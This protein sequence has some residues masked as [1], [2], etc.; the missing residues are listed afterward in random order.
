MTNDNQLGGVDGGE[1]TPSLFVPKTHHLRHRSST[2]K[3]PNYL[4]TETYSSEDNEKELA[5][6]LKRIKDYEQLVIDCTPTAHAII[7]DLRRYLYIIYS[8]TRKYPNYSVR[9]KQDT[10]HPLVWVKYLDDFIYCEDY[11]LKITNK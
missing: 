9:I 6:R 7:K 1:Y 4:V 2:R 10:K 11:S 8:I 3:Y 5:A